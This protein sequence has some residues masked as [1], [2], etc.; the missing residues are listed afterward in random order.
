MKE[1]RLIHKHLLGDNIQNLAFSRDDSLIAAAGEGIYIGTIDGDALFEGKAKQDYEKHYWNLTKEVPW[2]SAYEMRWAKDN[3]RLW[4]AAGDF[5]EFSVETQQFR[6]IAEVKE[7]L[8]TMDINDTREL[9]ALAGEG[10]SKTNKIY[11]FNDNGEL[12]R[13]I[14]STHNRIVY[15]V[16]FSQDGTKIVSG[17]RDD[18]LRVWDVDTGKML[19]QY[20]LDDSPSKLF[21]CADENKFIVKLRY[22]T[23]LFSLDASGKISL[24]KNLAKEL[25][26]K[27]SKGLLGYSLKDDTVLSSDYF[28]QRG[29]FHKLAGEEVAKI[30]AAGQIDFIAP[31]NVRDIVALVFKYRNPP[32]VHFYST[33][34]AAAFLK[35]DQIVDWEVVNTYTKVADFLIVPYGKYPENWIGMETNNIRIYDSEFNEVFRSRLDAQI[36]TADFHPQ[37]QKVVYYQLNGKLH[38]INWSDLDRDAIDEARLNANTIAVDKMWY[39][40]WS[41]KGDKLAI[42][43]DNREIIVYDANLQQLAKQKLEKRV[44]CLAWSKNDDKI[45]VGADDGLLYFYNVSDST[46]KTIQ[47]VGIERVIDLACDTTHDEFIATS[48]RFINILNQDGFIIRK[49]DF[50]EWIEFKFPTPRPSSSEFAVYGYDREGHKIYMIDRNKPI[51]QCINQIMRFHTDWIRMLHWIDKDTFISRGGKIGLVF[52]KRI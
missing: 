26:T 36:Y 45:A 30:E 27:G 49:L 35:E 23:S 3:K 25:F 33:E 52:W 42:V 15:S 13:S 7:K 8:K 18:T 37:T 51:R 29:H 12:L 40:R 17:G 20:K 24:L 34:S 22:D 31:G 43:T 41:H 47:L 39:V 5:Y 21:R 6:R 48:H 46:V 38:I 28:Y 1:Y 10:N 9:I 2:I 4:L 14:E 19:D 11:I 32:E 50:N 16:M 44:F